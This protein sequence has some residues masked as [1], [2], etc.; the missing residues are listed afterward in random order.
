M[1]LRKVL[2]HYEFYSLVVPGRGSYG[3]S[4]PR[5]MAVYIYPPQT[6]LMRESHWDV[7]VVVVYA[8]R[9]AITWPVTYKVTHA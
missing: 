3:N 2:F 4:F 6:L 1:I 7:V 5:G 9:M 8:R